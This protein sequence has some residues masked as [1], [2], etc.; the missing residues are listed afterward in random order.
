MDKIVIKYGGH[1]AEHAD[2]S[3]EFAQNVKYLIENDL[4]ISVV[5]GG[6]P[7]I[8]KLLENLH[9]NS[10]FINGLRVTDEASL[11]VVEMVL[12]GQVNKAIIRLFAKYGVI[13]VG[14]SG[15]DADLFEA[16][17]INPELGKVGK[18]SKVNPR[19]PLDLIANGFTPVI[20]PLA[21]DKYKNPLNINADTAAGALAGAVKAG[22]FILISDVPGV[23]D[24]KDKI[25]AKLN[26]QEIDELIADGTIY[27]GMLPKVKAC[28]NALEAGCESA[29]IL[30]GRVR[31]SLRAFL[32]NHAPYGTKIELN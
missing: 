28:L 19:L 10:H 9:I 18:I 25:F 21:L 15:E 29:I 24:R 7:H 27:G 22:A 31:G 3:H 30:D 5:H 11:E 20:A 32:C 8:N 26:P 23:L 14:I 16:E 4:K 2:L 12:C 17:I 1:A 6:G 13:G